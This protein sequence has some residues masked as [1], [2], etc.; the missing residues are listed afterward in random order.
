MGAPLHPVASA[1][2]A[3]A[4]VGDAPGDSDAL[5]AVADLSFELK[6]FKFTPCSPARSRGRDL[7]F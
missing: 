7:Y 1:A 2:A 6:K 4:A 3:G 5:V